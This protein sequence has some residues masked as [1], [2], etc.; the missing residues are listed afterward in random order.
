METPSEQDTVSTIMWSPEVNGNDMTMIGSESHLTGSESFITGSESQ[1]SCS[2][3]FDE[4]LSD[5][6]MFQIINKMAASPPPSGE[7]HANKM[8]SPDSSRDIRPVNCIDTNGI[9]SARKRLSL[10]LPKEGQEE[11][12]GE[13]PQLDL[14]FKNKYMPVVGLRNEVVINV[15]HADEP[16]KY[17]LTKT[18]QVDGVNGDDNEK[19]IVQLK[20]SRRGVRVL[21]WPKHIGTCTFTV[22]SKGCKEAS[23]TLEIAGNNPV[24]SFSEDNDWPVAIAVRQDDSCLYISFMHH[25]S[26]YNS[27]GEFQREVLREKSVHFNDIAVDQGRHKMAVSMSGWRKDGTHKFRFQAIKLYSLTGTHL[28][29]IGRQHPLFGVSI[30]R[31]AFDPRGNLLVASKG[32]L[33]TCAKSTGV[34][35]RRVKAKFGTA[36]RIAVMEDGHIIVADGNR[37]HVYVFDSGFVPK[38]D[39]KVQLEI[40]A[41]DENSVVGLTGLTVDHFGH[42]L[43]SD[44][45]TSSVQ[46]YTLDGTLLVMIDSE[47]D[48]VKW[49]LALA[50]TRDGYVFVADHGN[51]CVKKF[52]YM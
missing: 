24:L 36:S 28:W 19:I 41:D 1:M 29:T 49:P 11:D 5:P 18:I 20:S 44:C 10:E 14:T 47:W 30:I 31:I 34:V 26:K 32:A 48:Y 39:F 17:L 38:N 35:E 45:L 3:S 22:T 33:C 7:S 50:V 52:R 15:F 46:V 40:E 27:D 4:S 9:L 42:I 43:V 23:F 21:Y 25:V 37:G 6:A 12:L 51:A 13:R 2:E 16:N 8:K